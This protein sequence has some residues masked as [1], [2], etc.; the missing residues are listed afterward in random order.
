MLCDHCTFSFFIFQEHLSIHFPCLSRLPTPKPFTSILHS[1]NR[2]SLSLTLIITLHLLPLKPS[3]MVRTKQTARR[4]PP[5]HNPSPIR[6]SFRQNNPSDEPLNIPALQTIFPPHF[7][8]HRPP[9]LNQTPPLLK[10]KV[11]KKQPS[12]SLPTRHDQ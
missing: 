9:N 11:K 10:P 4:A 1:L 8:H 3:T 7:E 5:F 2:L 6:P 12:S